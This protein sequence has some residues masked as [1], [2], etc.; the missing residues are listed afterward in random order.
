[1]ISDRF[2]GPVYDVAHSVLQSCPEWRAF[3]AGSLSR[4]DFGRVLDSLAPQLIGAGLPANDVH[5]AK[6]YPRSETGFVDKALRALVEKK[7]LPSSIYNQEFYATVASDMRMHHDHG[8]FATYI[9]PEEAR[10]LFAIADILKPRNA[11]FLGS[12]YGY[13]AHAAMITICAF[14]GRVLLVDPDP[15]AQTVAEKNIARAGLKQVVDVIISTGEEFLRYTDSSFDL[16]VLDAE[17]PRNH[18]DPEQR[19]KRVY[20]SLLRCVLPHTSS[21]TRLVCHN[22][23]FQDICE[24]HFFY[25]VIA[26][27]HS[28]LGQFL[29]ILAAEFPDFTEI[30][31]TEG[32]GVGKRR[33]A[34]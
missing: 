7:I 29:E 25:Q 26:R 20:S 34:Q 33:G 1:M 15:A 22:I 24:C 30:T 23:L 19:G 8:N 2:R 17:G 14:G 16:V 13:W 27:N 3:Q 28:E 4:K 31:S 10:L 21:G 6:R 9:Y 32:V 11:V 12:Y 5:F 18:P